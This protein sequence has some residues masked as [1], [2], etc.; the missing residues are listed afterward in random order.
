LPAW[1]A[2]RSSAQAPT[3]FLFAP[4]KWLSEWALKRSHLFH[5]I[6]LWHQQSLTKAQYTNFI[7]GA[8]KLGCK[9]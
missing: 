2:P 6:Q 1:L 4:L 7:N 8:R 3:G 5:T 9:V